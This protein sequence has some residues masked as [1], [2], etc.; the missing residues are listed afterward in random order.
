[1]L[2][3]ISN[4][5]TYQTL[6]GLGMILGTILCIFQPNFPIIRLGAD[7]AVQIMFAYLFLG[8][9][10]LI[11]KSPKLMF[12]SFTCCGVMCLFL[13]RSFNDQLMLPMLR[14]T[15]SIKVAHFNVSATTDYKNFIE[16]VKNSR[17]DIVSFQEVTPDWD[18][19]LK[20]ALKNDFPHSKS[21]V[22]IDFYGMAIYSKHKI[23]K[24]DTF[25]H[26]DVP[27]LIGKININKSDDQVFFI[28]THTTPPIDNASYQVLNEQLET[29]AK[30]AQKIQAPLIT[31]GDYNAMVWSFEIQNF[32]NQSGLKNSR[33]S[34]IPSFTNRAQSPN[35]YIFYSDHLECVGFETL[36]HS[37]SEKAG[38]LGQ[39]QFKTAYT[40]AQKPLQ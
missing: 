28:G 29:V 8:I 34:Y 3:L 21:M 32:K 6:F 17:A 13:K 40:N 35:D 10:F 22:R 36:Y 14:N 9:L 26:K 5:A 18:M 15:T 2:S 16:T 7:F 12:I 37:N 24:L 19:F 20:Q 33:R 38:I 31:F 23:S 1:M 11:L 4:K 30:K 39:Y 25:Y 27:N